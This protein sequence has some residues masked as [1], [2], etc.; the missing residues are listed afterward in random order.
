MIGGTAM[1]YIIFALIT[2]AIG[3]V[4][5]TNLGKSVGNSTTVAAAPTTPQERRAWMEK[6]VQAVT[7]GLDRTLPK[8]N[9]M[10]PH[11][12]VSR[13][14]ADP[15]RNSIDIIIDIKGPARLNGDVSAAKTAIL[16]QS[17]PHYMKTPLGREQV[18]LTTRF[19]YE[20]RSPALTIAISPNNCRFHVGKG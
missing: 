16:K 9:G 14:K 2:M 18:T 19:L 20:N 4:M 12:S 11:M 8:G 7:R 5:G 1:R 3:G 15:L 10:Q 6:Q 13:V 17:C